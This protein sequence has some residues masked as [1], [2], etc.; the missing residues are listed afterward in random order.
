M[1][2]LLRLKVLYSAALLIAGFLFLPPAMFSQIAEGWKWRFDAKST[3]Y[4]SS[5]AGKNNVYV[6]N[7]EHFVFALDMRTGGE[8]WR[9]RLRPE[10]W[11]DERGEAADKLILLERFESSSKAKL[12]ADRVVGLDAA[13]G[14]ESW[15]KDFGGSDIDGMR[16]SGSLIYL[17]VENFGLVVLEAASGAVKWQSDACPDVIG[18]PTISG[19]SVFVECFGG[20]V[21]A[22]DAETGKLQWKAGSR[23]EIPTDFVFS[24]DSV[25]Y[26]SSEKRDNENLFA[27]DKTTGRE[28]W[29]TPASNRYTDQMFADNLLITTSLKGASASAVN[30]VSGKIIWQ[31]DG[32]GNSP[33]K[34]LS[35]REERSTSLLLPTSSGG[36]L[37]FGSSDGNLLAVES[38]T[39][40]LVWKAKISEQAIKSPEIIGGNAL[41]IVV[42][43]KTYYLAATNLANGKLSWRMRLYASSYEFVRKD[44]LLFFDGDDNKLNVVAPL[45]V[46]RLARRRKNLGA[47]PSV[48]QVINDRSGI[49]SGTGNMRTGVQDDVQ[50]EIFGG[51]AYTTV[52]RNTGSKFYAIDVPTGARRLLAEHA[53]E[54]LTKAQIRNGVAY[55]LGSD[56]RSKHTLY[57]FDTAAGKMLWQADSPDGNA[58]L[59]PVVSD[60]YICYVSSYAVLHVYNLDGKQLLKKRLGLTTSFNQFRNS[61]QLVEISGDT[62]YFTEG[63][64]LYA[65]DLAAG[66]PVWKMDFSSRV[67]NIVVGSDKVFVGS[68]DENLYAVDKKTGVTSW[69]ANV[70]GMLPYSENNVYFDGGSVYYVSEA[71]YK[72]LLQAYDG[73]SGKFLWERNVGNSEIQFGGDY[74]FTGSVSRIFDKQTG[75]SVLYDDLLAIKKLSLIDAAS[76]YIVLAH[77]FSDRENDLKL[78][79]VDRKNQNRILWEIDFAKAESK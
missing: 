42:E 1:F 32:D 26:K 30:P 44:N 19:K 2:K 39:G 21:Y 71:R 35:G 74:V 76:D 63:N 9:Y 45:E 67:G 66:K 50:A 53:P 40:Q 49:G 55:Y 69:K 68:D 78:K 65:F 56:F 16:I 27:L 61:R 79:A 4:S 59:P 37:Y 77:D 23:G 14:K 46:E 73:R 7:A 33:V 13:T 48:A 18:A 64:S 31:I 36:K 6:Y 3:I 38:S 25:F 11:L 41:T 70:G 75:K 12:I 22:V 43:N 51:K 5:L 72:N 54:Q 8:K 57:A 62:I 24:G 52:S 15:Q 60:K 20:K 58:N 10:T 17:N 47:S 29:K 28:R 34:D